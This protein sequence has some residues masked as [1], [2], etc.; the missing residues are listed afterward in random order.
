MASVLAAIEQNSGHVDLSARFKDNATVAASPSGSTETIIC[1]LPAIPNAIQ[2]GS[3]IRLFAWAALT[4]GTNGTAVELKIRRTD[5]SG[6]TVVSSGALTAVAANLMY[7]SASGLDVGVVLPGQVY[8]A[9]LTVTG[10]SDASTVS[11]VHLCAT[12]I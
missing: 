8:V 11:A 6:T 2:Q 9:T 7:V 1:T 5:A 10:G 4:V 3:G 12:I